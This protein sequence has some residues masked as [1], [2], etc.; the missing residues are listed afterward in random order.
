MQG[1]ELSPLD[2]S[3]S[4]Q[5]ASWDENWNQNKIRKKRGGAHVQFPKSQ[6]SEPNLVREARPKRPTV[7]NGSRDQ[8]TNPSQRVIS[9]I[10]SSSSQARQ[11]LKTEA[12]RFGFAPHRELPSASEHTVSGPILHNIDSINSH[13]RMPELS[14]A[15]AQASLK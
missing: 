13:L 10:T 2:A 1:I 9:S 15:P 6:K 8:P 5:L 7:R 14:L 12:G 11:P 3:G 4:P